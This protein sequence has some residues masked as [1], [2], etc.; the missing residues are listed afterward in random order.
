M[1]KASKIL[2]K[3]AKQNGAKLPPGKLVATQSKEVKDIISL[4][5]RREDR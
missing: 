3:I 5:R 2:E 4:N 1:E